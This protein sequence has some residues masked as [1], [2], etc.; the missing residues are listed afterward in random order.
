MKGTPLILEAPQGHSTYDLVEQR[1][2]RAWGTG[3]FPTIKKIFKVIED[4]SFLMPYD[5]Y[6][7][8]VGNE[9]FRYHGTRQ[10][11]TL[12]VGGNTQLCSSGS[13]ALCS[14]LRTSFKVSLANP[15]GSFGAGIY[16][17]SSASKARG[18]SGGPIILTKVVLGKAYDT[19]AG[20]VRSC[21]NGY[22]SVVHAANAVN[23][24]TIVYTDDAIRPVF[25]LFI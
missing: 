1:F 22:D 13:C 25:L 6:K 4:K 15:S 3:S 12:G 9:V 16:S 2:K 10:T 24:E 14:I 21:P 20:F 5:R 18:Y 8:R 11:C 19:S 23:N 17:S 7:R